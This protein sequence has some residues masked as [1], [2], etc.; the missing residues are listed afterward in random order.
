MNIDFR[1]PNSGKVDLN[2]LN[3]MKSL[4]QFGALA[5]LGFIG[6]TSFSG[7]AQASMTFKDSQSNIYIGGMSP[8][9]EVTFSYPGTPK[10]SSARA[11]LC[12]AVV[13]RG[14]GGVPISGTIKVDNVSIDASTLPTQL[15]PPC[16]SSGSFAESRTSNFKTSDG[17]VVVVGK[18]ANNFYGVETPENAT[19]RARA[20]A[21]G[22]VR[23]APN[24]RFT[25][26]STQQVAIGS[27][28]P[29]AISSIETK[30]APLCR[31]SIIYFPQSW[32]GGSPF[33]S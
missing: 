28:S 12:G 6:A 4:K 24:A 32:L 9:Q 15:L 30:D 10:V 25:H 26:A 19:R 21:C 2:P 33:G 31:G 8:Q 14:S 22:I 18:T 20:N 13:V 7:V 23:V 29:T 1:I 11:N 27:D 5:T 3:P 16:S 17:Q